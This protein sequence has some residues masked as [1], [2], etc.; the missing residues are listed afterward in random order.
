MND[1]ERLAGRVRPPLRGAANA[2][3]KGEL[4]L[5]WQPRQ[6]SWRQGSAT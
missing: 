4:G 2:K 6:P 1:S 5:G 3:A